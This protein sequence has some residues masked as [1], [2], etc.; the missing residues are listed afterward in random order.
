VSPNAACTFKPSDIG[1][2]LES[3]QLDTDGVVFVVKLESSPISLTLRR[4]QSSTD[5]FQE[6]GETGNGTLS[7][8]TLAER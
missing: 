4:A 5:N 6:V 7:N 1:P 3:V 2:G 8:L